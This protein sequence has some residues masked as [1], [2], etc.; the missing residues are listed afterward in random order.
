[1]S[2]LDF[3]SKPKTLN[4]EST[5]CC[6]PSDPAA[7][8]DS[9]CDWAAGASESVCRTLRNLDG[10]GMG[11]ASASARAAAGIADCCALP[12]GG[13]ETMLTFLPAART[14]G[15]AGSFLPPVG[16]DGL[17]LRADASSGRPA[18]TGGERTCDRR[19]GRGRSTSAGASSSGIRVYIRHTS[20]T[21]ESTSPGSSFG[22]HRRT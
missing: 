11:T 18:G 12:D 7:S 6:P 22:E 2:L 10:T 8:A 3:P 17:R 16:A 5:G 4:V 21:A 9:A 15:G 14:A 19:R 13:S 1:M 20:C